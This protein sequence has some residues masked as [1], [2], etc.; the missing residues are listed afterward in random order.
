MD[1]NTLTI[2]DLVRASGAISSGLLDVYEPQEDSPM[3]KDMEMRWF[4]MEV[5]SIEGE[6]RSGKKKKQVIMGA[7]YTCEACHTRGDSY[8]D[9]SLLRCSKCRIVWYCSVECQRARWSEHKHVCGANKWLYD[10][11]DPR[12][13]DVDEPLFNRK[14]RRAKG[15]KKKKPEYKWDL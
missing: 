8:A 10:C 2:N 5:G 9:K 3:N 1:P 14:Q 4:M 13:L 15:E 11:D 7:P 12:T 6:G